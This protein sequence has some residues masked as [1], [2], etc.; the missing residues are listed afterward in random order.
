MSPSAGRRTARGRSDAKPSAR[1]A[2]PVFS[3][4]APASKGMSDLVLG[5]A[6]H[7]KKNVRVDGVV[8]GLPLAA[9]PHEFN[10]L[11][12]DEQFSRQ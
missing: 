9:E 5:R 4:N 3:A 6:R 8:F 11:N 2:G 1:V 10:E 7:P 12:R